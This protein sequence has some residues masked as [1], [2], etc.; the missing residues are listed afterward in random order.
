[1]EYTLSEHKHRFSIWTAARAVQ[2]SW[3][4]TYNI[5]K[6]IQLLD[7]QDFVNNFKD[8]THQQEFDNLHMKWCDRIINEFRV[9]NIIASYGRAAKIIAIYLK[10]SIIMGT[11]DDDKQVRFI[12]PPIDRIL[13]KNL[14]NDIVEFNSIRKLNWTQLDKKVYWDLV[15]TIRT[16]LGMFDWRLE[17]YWR[18]EIEND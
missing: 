6:V 12:H 11:L 17:V 18:P 3:T 1:M 5:S 10:T 8:I 16:Q 4:T 9:L 7:L 2:R 15:H 13:L 14:P